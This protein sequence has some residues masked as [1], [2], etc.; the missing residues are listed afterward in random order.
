MS[1]NNG[2]SAHAKHPWPRNTAAGRW[3]GFG[4][5]LAMLP[6]PF[7]YEVV[8]NLTHPGDVVLDP[9]CGRGNA[10]FAAAVLGRPAVGIDINPVAWLFTEVKFHPASSPEPVIRRLNE[11]ARARRSQDRRGRNRFET[12]AWA[13]EVRA[14]L[15]AARRELDWMGSQVD[16]TLMAFIALH[17]QDKLGSGLSNAMSPTIAYSPPYAVRWWTDMG[18]LKAPDIEPVAM[19]TDK[20]LRR[21]RYGVPEQAAGMGLLGDAREKLSAQED[22][23]AALLIT[24]P[25]YCGVADY[26]NDH[27]IRLWLL[28]HKFRKDWQK[29]ARFENKANYRQL[30]Q[31][32]FQESRRHL[33]KGAAVLVRSDQRHQTAEMCVAAL[34]DV[35]P[36]RRIL[37]R[38]TTAPHKSVSVHHGRGG[39]KAKEID[40]LLPARRGGQWWARR[41]FGSVDEVLPNLA[42]G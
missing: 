24:S 3:Y 31:D 7:I 11:I 34:Q 38:P 21:Y 42:M 30:I 1:Q 33:A 5:Y 17:I 8:N 32:V 27:W 2:D 6:P 19:L 12:M 14:L 22:I 16:R 37:A 26:W 39:T 35:W 9:F 25:P 29:A 15:K 20:I 4:R 28:G 18:L 10:P 36:R 23:N 41:G 40:L 13:P